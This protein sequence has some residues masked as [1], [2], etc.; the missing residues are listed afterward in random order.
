MHDTALHMEW[1]LTSSREERLAPESVTQDLHAA[2]LMQNLVQPSPTER[3]AE[4][5]AH[6]G[7][8]GHSGHDL[9]TT[10]CCLVSWMSPLV[11]DLLKTC[12]F[13]TLQQRT[14]FPTFLLNSTSV[15]KAAS[16][17]H[18]RCWGPKEGETRSHGLVSRFLQ[19]SGQGISEWFPLLPVNFWLKNCHRCFPVSY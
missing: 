11:T 19:L 9:S 3:Y 16:D 15:S 13:R 12:F 10:F 5:P 4:N 17:Q 1:G 8:E 6:A 18:T 7:E 2:P 14:S